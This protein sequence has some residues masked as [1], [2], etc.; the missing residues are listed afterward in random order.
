MGKIEQ[1]GVAYRVT[2]GKKEFAVINHWDDISEIGEGHLIVEIH[3][4]GEHVMNLVVAQGIDWDYEWYA[5]KENK[6]V[7]LPHGKAVLVTTGNG[8][9]IVVEDKYDWDNPERKIQ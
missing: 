6:R 3:Q 1:R 8:G 2:D 7:D 4:D 5:D 9:G